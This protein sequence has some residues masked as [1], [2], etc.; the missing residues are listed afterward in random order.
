MQLPHVEGIGR[1]ADAAGDLRH[2]AGA[3]RED[4]HIGRGVVVAQL[5]SGGCGGPRDV[6]QERPGD[7]AL[8][9]ARCRARSPALGEGEGG[10]IV[11]DDRGWLLVDAEDGRDARGVEGGRHGD[12]DEVVSQLAYLREQADQ[13]VSLERALVHLVDDHRID[14]LEAGVVQ[15]P[16]QQDAGRDEFDPRLLCDRALASDREPHTSAERG[17]VELCEPARGGPGGDATRLGDDDA[18]GRTRGEQRWHKR[19][20]AGAWRRAHHR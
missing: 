14:A 4:Q 11:V 3:R 7:T 2:L 15:Q 19:R 18:A 17:T 16:P 13:E 20:L 8:V 10:N 1:V 12:E 5:P 9:E 6:I